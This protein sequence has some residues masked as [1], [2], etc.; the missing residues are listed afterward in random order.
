MKDSVIIDVDH[1]SMRFDL[2]QERFSGLKDMVILFTKGRLKFNHFYAL[3]DVTLSIR[4]G[5][6]WALIGRNG[7]GKS[8]LLKVISGIYE[9]TNGC[10]TRRGSI[11]PL[12]ELGAGFDMELTASENLYLNGAV[13]GHNRK[14]MREHFDEI[15]DFAELWDFVNV[16]VKN[17]SS[18]MI[19]RLG[20]AIATVVSADILVIDEILAV[21]DANFQKKCFQRMQ[22]IR[23]KGATILFVSHDIYQVKRMCQKAVWLDHGVIQ[24]IGAVDEVCNAYEKSLQTEPAEES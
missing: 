9:P 7:C 1:V 3:K 15:I 6:S 11:A 8:T 21:G 13:L 17:F 4:R 14:F 16:P 10:L 24:K 22:E 12:I 2:A 5:E 18:G 23:K 19:A 20:F